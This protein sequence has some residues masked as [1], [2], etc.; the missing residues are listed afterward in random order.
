M[1]RHWEI[2]LHLKVRQLVLPSTSDVEI[3]CKPRF[4]DAQ[5]SHV[6]TVNLN[7]FYLWDLELWVLWRSSH[8]LCNGSALLFCGECP[9]KPESCTLAALGG[10]R[11]QQEMQWILA[12]HES[13]EKL[14]W[15]WETCKLLG[16]TSLAQHRSL[17]GE[18]LDR[19]N[20]QI[21]YPDF[22]LKELHFP[23][24]GQVWMYWHFLIGKKFHG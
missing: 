12:S 18:L 23:Q 4:T 1:A 20:K 3:S 9:W 6:A 5:S 11:I 21:S 13:W 2:M 24:I 14:S 17:Q 15:S 22:H 19:G 7:I 8:L 16:N 10:Q